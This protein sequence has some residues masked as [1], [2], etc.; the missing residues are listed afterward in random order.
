ML[1]QKLHQFDHIP[2][3]MLHNQSHIGIS[4]VLWKLISTCRG[5]SQTAHLP[6]GRSMHF[7]A[8][9]E[10]KLIH[11]E[12][13][14]RTCTLQ[15]H[16]M[17]GKVTLSF[18]RHIPSSKESYF[19]GIQNWDVTWCKTSCAARK[20]SPYVGSCQEN[21]PLIQGWDHCYTAISTSLC[22]YSLKHLC[23]CQLKSNAIF[24]HNLNFGSKNIIGKISS[25]SPRDC[26]SSLHCHHYFSLTFYLG[27]THP[28][29]WCVHSKSWDPSW[30]S[31]KFHAWM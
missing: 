4:K 20:P 28:S 16:V 14:T 10:R 22:L 12:I 29:H 26:V 17:D 25:A 9:I 3:E 6:D 13:S 27:S 30:F 15:H 18:L 21:T 23:I 11:K 19:H 7:H 5:H 8:R 2:I 24:S 31:R 1:L